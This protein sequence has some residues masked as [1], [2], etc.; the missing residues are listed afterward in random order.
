METNN[1]VKY[2]IIGIAI[3]VCISLKIYFGSNVVVND[4]DTAIE[5]VVKAESGYDIT[6]IVDAV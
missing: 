5:S 6:P 2:S 1:I 4:V 3:V